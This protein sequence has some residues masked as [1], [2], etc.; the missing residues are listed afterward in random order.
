MLRKKNGFTLI[1]LLIV[2]AIF[3]VLFGVTAP[4]AYR[5]LNRHR[6]AANSME[7]LG[8]FN[9][10]RSIAA[11][12]NR[13]F[14]VRFNPGAGTVIVFRDIDGDWVRDPNPAADE[15]MIISVSVPNFIT[16]ASPP[17]TEFDST[18][19]KLDFRFDNKGLPYDQVGNLTS[20]KVKLVN[21]INEQR[22]VELLMSGHARVTNIQPP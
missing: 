19:T 2:M 18:N 6:L 22:W 16:I 14:I 20:G 5:V 15:D 3:A 11:K 13:D 17:D 21:E 1:E 4:K 10:T 12:E 7:I 8:I 9:K